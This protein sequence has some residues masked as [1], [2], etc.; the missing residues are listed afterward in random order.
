MSVYWYVPAPGPAREDSMKRITTT[1]VAALAF[2]G[3]AYAQTPPQPTRAIT[4]VRGDLY[5]F[6]DNQHYTVFLVTPDGIILADPINLQA[7]TWLKSELAKRFPN[8]PVRF[9]LQS[10]HD[11]DHASGATVF[12]DTAELIGHAAF[13]AELKSAQSSL[14]EFFAGMDQN[15]N[16][17][18]EKA[19][20][21]SS[22]F[23]GFLAA[24]DRNGD[25]TVAPPELYT[26]VIPVESTFTDRR[27]VT[28]GGKSVQLI[29]PGT[30]HAKDMAVLLFPAERVVFAVDYLPVKSLP[31]GFA[32]STPRDVITSVRSV[33]ALDFDTIVPG[34][35]EMGTK[36]DVT[37][38]R[39]Y[40]EELVAGVQ[41]GIKSGKSVEQ[42]QASN[43]LEKYKAWP[44]YGM[45]RNQNIA[46]VYAI[47]KAG[48]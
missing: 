47:L 2:A 17:R 8:R 40:V 21:Q 38:Y 34:H 29:H 5:R 45:Q 23:G 4:N 7:A 35:G 44:N 22:P 26:D 15:K 13:N 41:D 24:Q 25:G 46:E 33:E 14:P 6:Q 28:L 9:V 10:H 39:Q 42:L 3:T 48:K 32:P 11:F 43:M 19:E 16:G 37:A 30:A 18:L 1:L 36:A 27:T 31:F 12:N 20:L